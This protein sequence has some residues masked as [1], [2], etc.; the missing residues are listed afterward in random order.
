MTYV[1]TQRFSVPF[2]YPVFFTECVFDLGNATL[3][4]ALSR[5]EPSRRH[6]ALVVIDSGVADAIPDLVEQ[7]F[8]YAAAFPEQLELV[9]APL[10]IPGGEH[11]KGTADAVSKLHAAFATAHL[12]RQSFVII[13][14]GGAVHDVAGYAAATAHRGVRVVRIPTTVEGQNDSGVGVKN[15]LN[16]YGTKNYLGTFAPPFAVINDA[17]FIETLPDRDRRSGMA[18]AVKVALLRDAE[19]F[20]WLWSQCDALTRFEPTAMQHMIRRSAELHLE[21][22]AGSGDPFEF[23]AA[24]PLDFGHWAAHKLEILSDYD[25]RHGEAV[26]IGIAIDARYAA[27]RGWLDEAAVARICVLLERLGFNLWHVTVASRNGD[28]RRVVMDGLDE[29]R[30]HLGGELTLTMLTAIGTS[31]DTSDI[32]TTLMARAID[33]LEY[34]ATA[35]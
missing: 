22:I 2:E 31:I 6:R 15:G 7:I 12:D 17:A 20:E 28:Q 21:H 25:L 3:L 10:V 11:T 30:E 18:E 4:N 16:A 9:D 24:K 23:G 8:G 14:G 27:E 34:R 19:F 32:D 33:W 35:S 26:A 5:I 13:V 1:Y 29:F